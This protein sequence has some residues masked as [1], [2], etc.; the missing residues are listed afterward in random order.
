MNDCRTRLWRYVLSNAQTSTEYLIIWTEIARNK[1]TLPTLWLEQTRNL[2]FTNVDLPFAIWCPRRLVPRER[3][4]KYQTNGQTTGAWAADCYLTAVHLLAF[5]CREKDDVVK[6]ASVL[7]CRDNE[8]C[9][10]IKPTT[11]YR[12]DGWSSSRDF[13]D[14][15]LPPSAL[16]VGDG[17][18]LFS[19]SVLAFVFLFFIWLLFSF[20]FVLMF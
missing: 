10:E 15:I 8:R 13:R 17:A 6:P 14:A 7:H 11:C 3:E 5:Y 19:S 9:K 1:I 18:I 20:C 4:R 2:V 16:W 12:S